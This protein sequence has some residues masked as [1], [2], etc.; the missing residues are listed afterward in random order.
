MPDSVGAGPGSGD[1]CARISIS[2]RHPASRRA[3]AGHT[4]PLE[5]SFD[6]LGGHPVPRQ[7]DPVGVGVLGLVE[8]RELTLVGLGVGLPLV[9]AL[10]RW[11]KWWT[12]FAS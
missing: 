12:I 7:A 3:T 10:K 5:P 9:G 4:C 11:S 2:G 8:L 6:L 1:N